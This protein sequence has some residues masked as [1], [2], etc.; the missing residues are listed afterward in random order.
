MKLK[1]SL[2]VAPCATGRTHVKLTR[3]LVP[4]SKAES[5]AMVGQV[6]LLLWCLNP[7]LGS[8]RQRHCVPGGKGEVGGI[9]S[10]HRDSCIVRRQVYHPLDTT[11]RVG[12]GDR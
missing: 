5:E 4:L 6:P 11:G 10:F 8:A 3:A 7:V 2:A 9:H 1:T 12:L